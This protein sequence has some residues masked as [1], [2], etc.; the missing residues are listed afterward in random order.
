MFGHSA[1][2][3]SPFLADS[4][5]VESFPTLF[6]ATQLLAPLNTMSTRA[7]PVNGGMAEKPPPPPDDLP[8]KGDSDPPKTCANSS[9][10]DQANGGGPLRVVQDL[11]GSYV[12][13]HAILSSPLVP[14]A[15]DQSLRAFQAASHS[16]FAQQV[17]MAGQGHDVYPAHWKAANFAQNSSVHLSSMRTA[18]TSAGLTR[19]QPT[20]V[21][22]EDEGGS[23]KHKFR[24]QETATKKRS[25]FAGEGRGVGIGWGMS[26]SPYFR[27]HLMMGSGIGASVL[28]VKKGAEGGG[29][30]GGK[31][32]RGG[33][34]NK[35]AVEEA[36]AAEEAAEAHA[37]E[38]ADFSNMATPF[39]HAVLQGA[40]P[41]S[42]PFAHAHAYPDAYNAALSHM[43]AFPTSNANVFMGNANVNAGSLVQMPQNPAGARGFDLC[44]VGAGLIGAAAARHAAEMGARKFPFS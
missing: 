29:Q 2:K 1:I 3:F 32:G 24:W 28:K 10:H 39:P 34:K 22:E 5:A 6:V 17:A 8:V 43:A 37:Q 13:K 26:A 41:T 16:H 12:V 20:A 36:D 23:H 4:W 30:G 18:A 25:R 14:L 42:N 9:T 44:V 15:I 11:D 35:R 40:H 31:K 38:V 33:K 7:P 27:N 19:E 21:H